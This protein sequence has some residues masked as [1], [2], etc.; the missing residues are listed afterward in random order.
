LLYTFRIFERHMGSPKYGAFL[1]IVGIAGK[2]MEIGAI[3]I[4]QGKLRPQPGPYSAIYAAFVLYYAT[5]PSSRGSSG[6]SAKNSRG[7]AL[8]SDK[9]MTY[10][11]GAQ[12]F[13]GSGIS[14]IIP[15][16]SGVLMGL[17]Y[18][19][20][21]CRL[22]K[23]KLPS[24]LLKAFKTLKPF[25]EPTSARPAQPQ[26]QT[27]GNNVHMGGPVG[28]AGVRSAQEQLIGGGMLFGP[29][30]PQQPLRQRQVQSQAIGL[31]PPSDE[32]IATLMA[33]GFD[34]EH[35]MRALQASSNNV[36]IAANRLL[37][38]GL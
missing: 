10:L 22:D 5:I 12:L 9:T 4:L 29:R 25:V 14:S 21:M 38:G 6:S 34:R 3:S 23:L 31:E 32:S 24:Y 8:L 15:A 30:S 37:A 19:T 27:R 28:Q 17:A 11:L 35:V 18:R 2:A 26:R 7:L 36:D 16:M 20:G 13:W 33:L 1:A